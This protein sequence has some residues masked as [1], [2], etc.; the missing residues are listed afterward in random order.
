MKFI[1]I[2]YEP[3]GSTHVIERADQ[4]SITLENL[5]S[6]IRIGQEGVRVNG[7]YF[8]DLKGE[9]SNEL[10]LKH[11]NRLKEDLS[12][13]KKLHLLGLGDVGSTLALGLKL[14]GGDVID[15]LGLFDLNENQ[16]RRWEMEL[17]QIAINP[18]LKVETIEADALFDCDVFIFCASR[19]VPKVGEEAGDVRMRQ[20]ELN[21]ELIGLYAKKAR[22]AGFKGIFSVVSDPVDLLCKAVYEYSNRDDENNWDGLGLYPEQVRGFGLGVMDG[23][24]KYYSNKMTLEYPAKGRVFG[25][26]GKALVVS[27]DITIPDDNRSL[28]LTKQ[29]IEANLEVR[30]LGFKPYIA[31]AIS[32]GALSI[33]AM[34]AGNWHY[35]AT[36]VQGVYWGTRNRLTETGTEY[37]CVSLHASLFDR[38]QKS[39]KTLEDIWAQSNL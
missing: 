15:T 23:R 31:P 16:K 19:F 26:H 34:L 29:V 10:I 35:S 6:G 32:S 36:Y 33:V 4:L 27:A 5:Y 1:D 28:A 37:E 11:L 7:N 25:P 3:K 20:F 12:R 14:L 39:Y 2:H 8:L 17:N 24:A 18:D 21:A 9:V 13:K 22:E 30:A 38:I